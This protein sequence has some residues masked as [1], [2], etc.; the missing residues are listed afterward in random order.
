MSFIYRIQKIKYNKL[1]NYGTIIKNNYLTGC[2]IFSDWTLINKRIYT[3]F[4]C[5][6]VLS[7]YKI[8]ERRTYCLLLAILLLAQYKLLQRDRHD[9]FRN[10]ISFHSYSISLILVFKAIK[11]RRLLYHN[12][13]STYSSD[14]WKCMGYK[15]SNS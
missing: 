15:K 2:K 8:L 10:F 13:T 5:C 7:N 1:L 3:L 6:V 12:T 11:K 14:N 9:V 4:T